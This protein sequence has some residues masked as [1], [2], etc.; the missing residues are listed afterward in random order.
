MSDSVTHMW[1]EPCFHRGLHN[2]IEGNVLN[3]THF[4]KLWNRKHIYVFINI[5]DLRVKHHL[6]PQTKFRG[7]KGAALAF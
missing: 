3:T 2:N 6:M 4:M 1:R 5:D 7:G